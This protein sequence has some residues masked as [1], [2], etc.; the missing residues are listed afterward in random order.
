MRGAGGDIEG[1][2][3]RSSLEGLGPHQLQGFFEGW[4]NPPSAQTLHC[5]LAGSYRISLAVEDGGRWWASLRPS[6]TG[7]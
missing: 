7:C 5:L 6:A 3:L 4:P 1:M 2:E